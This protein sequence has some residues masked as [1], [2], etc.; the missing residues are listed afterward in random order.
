VKKR[1]GLVHWKAEEA[2][3]LIERLERA[4]Y[5]VHYGD[6]KK[7][8]RVSELKKLDPWAA[9][10]DLTRLPSQGKYWAAELRES[11]LRHLPI[12]FVDG[13]A[14]R[15]ERVRAAIPDAEYVSVDELV[16]ALMKVE[17]VA[18][19]VQPERMM[20]S[21]R[22][23][24][25]KMGVKAST[26]VGVYDAPRGYAKVIGEL[27][28]GAVLEESPAEIAPVSVWFVRDAEAYLAG[29][30]AMKKIAA[31]SKLWVVYPKQKKGAT[32]GITQF[33][34]REAAIE[35][36]LVDYKIC[37]VDETWTGMAFAVKK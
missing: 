37:R 3:P 22:S 28:S 4:G 6:E 1:V 10:V 32:Q 14:Q 18:H 31:K 29:L 30:R 21:T 19:P 34:L 17:P 8:L 7:P 36:G 13:D 12:L 35:I 15:V 9:V 24:A 20:A 16:A 27:P 5:D 23:A 33:T 26:R 2:R 11:S 25:L